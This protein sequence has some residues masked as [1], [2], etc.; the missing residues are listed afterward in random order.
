M[1]RHA[2]VPAC[3][4]IMS[5]DGDGADMPACLTINLSFTVRCIRCDSVVN[6]YERELHLGMPLNM[7]NTASFLIEYEFPTVL[8]DYRCTM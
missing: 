2:D 6:N 8:E 3:C 5:Y 1:C 4:R 7:T